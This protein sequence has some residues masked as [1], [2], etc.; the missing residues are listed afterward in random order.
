MT[1]L[2]RP[3]LYGAFHRIEPVSAA[4]R[5]AACTTRSSARSARAATSSAAI[6]MLPRA[7]RSA[8]WSRSATPAPTASAM[9][10]N[11]NR[12]PLPAEVLVDDGRWRVI[13][14]R[15]TVDDMLALESSD[16]GQC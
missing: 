3:A 5:R 1:E 6:A 7:R 9:A 13:R 15:Q 12:R 11:Y 10:S 4:R 16:A 8:I 2:M 14:R